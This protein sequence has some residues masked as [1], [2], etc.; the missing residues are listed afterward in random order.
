MKKTLVIHPQDP[1]TDFLCGIY[2]GLGF[3]EMRKNVNCKSLLMQI[4]RFER[5]ILLGH[6]SPQGLAHLSDLIIDWTMS[7]L[8]KGKEVIA[9]WCHAKAYMEKFGLRGF[10]TDMFISEVGEA[11]YYDIQVTQDEVDES[12]YLFARLMRENL[13]KPDRINKILAGY[14]SASN[15]VIQYN[16]QRLFNNA[17]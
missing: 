13:N 12:N 1:T 9:I 11:K 2:D 8:L 14:Q 6:G 4:P 15:K 7:S 16:N 5:I 17:A 3:V 10:Y